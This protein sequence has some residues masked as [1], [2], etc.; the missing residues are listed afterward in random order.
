MWSDW[1]DMLSTM[2]APIRLVSNKQQMPFLGDVLTKH[3]KAILNSSHC[4]V[5]HA[6]EAILENEFLKA[7]AQHCVN[8]DISAMFLA[9]TL[10]IWETNARTKLLC[11][12]VFKNHFLA[13]MKMS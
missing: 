6:V 13:K 10:K 11:Q 3:L 7:C 4:M 8:S 9:V 1:G 12:K 5:I 2:E